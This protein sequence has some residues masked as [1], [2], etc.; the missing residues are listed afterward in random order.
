MKGKSPGSL[1]CFPANGLI[2]EHKASL[3]FLDSVQTSPGI[4]GVV[5][6]NWIKLLYSPHESLWRSVSY[7][8]E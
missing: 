4:P 8:H 5:K 1:S 3:A 7:E 2:S 6:S